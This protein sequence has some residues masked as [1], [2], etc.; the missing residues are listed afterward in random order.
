MNV[1]S[2]ATNFVLFQL[3]SLL[4]RYQQ[5]ATVLKELESLNIQNQEL[6]VLKT[7][8]KEEEQFS[9]DL[10]RRMQELHEIL[11]IRIHPQWNLLSEGISKDQAVEAL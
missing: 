7:T 11:T 10:R 5:R 6:S 8:M 4:Y 9:S 1:C 2:H 3:N